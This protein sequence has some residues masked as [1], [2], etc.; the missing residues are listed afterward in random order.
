M[1]PKG[2]HLGPFG[3]FVGWLIATNSLPLVAITGMLGVGLFGAASSNLIR[4]R[5][6]DAQD[7]MAGAGG[8]LVRGVSAAFVVYLGVKGG[9]SI[10]SAQPNDPNPYVLLLTC[11]VAAVFSQDVWSQAYARF[12]QR[13]HSDDRRGDGEVPASP[14]GR[15][16]LPSVGGAPSAPGVPTSG[17]PDL[18]S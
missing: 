2:G 16:D 9:L 6:S 15:Q 11:L 14:T 10:F 5:R 12:F 1:P 13:G 3:F 7:Q 18:R 17:S 4:G 8:V